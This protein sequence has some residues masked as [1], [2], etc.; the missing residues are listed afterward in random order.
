MPVAIRLVAVT[1]VLCLALASSLLAQGS[2]FSMTPAERKELAGYR[3]TMDNIKQAVAVRDKMKALEKDPKVKAQVEDKEATSLDDAIRKLDAV[4]EAHT[5]IASSGLTTKDFM[6]TVLQ[7]GYTM[8]AYRMQA[9]GGQ[10]ANAA[11]RLPT[12]PQ[13]V[14]FF[15]A[16]QAEI[17]QLA[18]DLPMAGPG[19]GD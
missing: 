12:S 19:G 10:A 17:G 11:A 2:S 9:M 4:P 3:L 18:K 15:A 7:V 6:F 8:A 1:S 14:Q 5:A 13:N 16:H